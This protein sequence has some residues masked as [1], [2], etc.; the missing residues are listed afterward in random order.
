MLNELIENLANAE[1][2]REKERAYRQLERVGVDRFTADILVKETN[3]LKGG[4][5]K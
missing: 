4:K 5:N 3:T 1:N 2:V